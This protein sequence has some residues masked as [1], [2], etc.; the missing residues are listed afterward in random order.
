MVQTLQYL[1]VSLLS[2]VAVLSIVVCVHEFGHFRVGRWCGIAVKSF[3]LGI[4]PEWFGWTDKHG[5][6]WKV[7]TIPLG[8]FVSWVDDTDG[9]STLP[10]SSDDQAL[11]TAEARKLGHFRA[12][13]LWARAAATVAGPLAN[14]I[15]AIL[16]FGF[17]AFLTGRDPP[18]IDTVSPN[19]PASEAGM[20]AGDVVVQANGHDIRSFDGLR[21]V[22]MSSS[23]RPIS[24]VV[25][26][27]GEQ[28]AMAVTP[29]E[30]L[31]DTGDGRQTRQTIVGV[32]HTRDVAL[33]ER[34]GPLG[35]LAEGAWQTWD[36]VALTGTYIG[37]VLTGRAEPS[38]IAGPVGI[39]NASGQT[40]T[41]A[42]SVPEATAWERAI[43]LAL[44]LLNLAAFL[45]VAVGLANLLPIPILDGGHLVFYAIE[46]LRGGKPLPPVAQEWAFRAGFA[47]MASLFLLANWND[48]SRLLPGQGG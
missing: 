27:A 13:P 8:G 19:S 24:L 26:R 45:S 11:S 48:I 20:L 35:A 47:I 17:L 16:A 18:R 31:M 1:L 36:N 9:T 41:N 5:T 38:Q 3:S 42:L 37:Q 7:S 21:Q 14:F 29:R 32:G 12:M 39:F 33:M 34:L 44:S 6:R 43:M 46:A 4:G 28:V 25:E 2:F 23:G 30:Q 40:A 10:A 15:F 22:I